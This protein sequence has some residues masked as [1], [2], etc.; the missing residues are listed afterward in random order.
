MMADY[1]LATSDENGPVIRTEDGACI[2]NDPANRDWVEY[3]NWLEEGNTPDPYVPPPE[4]EPSPPS[5]E[6]QVL[7]DHE[8]RLRALEGEPPLSF[9]EF[10]KAV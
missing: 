8:N 7:Y 1:Q 2:P 10:K 6:D 5:T 3:Q 9:E 4:P